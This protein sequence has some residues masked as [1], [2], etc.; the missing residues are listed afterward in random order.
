MM[1]EHELLKREIN[2][3]KLREQDAE[4]KILQLKADVSKKGKLLTNVETREFIL[5]QQLDTVQE[6]IEEEKTH[7]MNENEDLQVRIHEFENHVEELKSEIDSLKLN[8]RRRSTIEDHKDMTSLLTELQGF[9][10]DHEAEETGDISSRPRRK[11]GKGDMLDNLNKLMN[12]KNKP[13]K[14]KSLA[15]TVNKKELEE[16]N[17]KIGTYEKRIQSMTK[18]SGALQ[19]KIK[20]EIKKVELNKKHLA[21]KDQEIES[22]RQK[23]LET[24]M[25]YSEVINDINEQ[26]DSSYE[27]NRKLKRKLR[28]SKLGTRI[29][30]FKN[31]VL[32]L[33]D[34]K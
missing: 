16:M 4:K 8:R 22:L 15:S 14:K 7:M 11:T 25:G 3:Y 20:E 17:K 1:Q 34:Q 30:L 27:L 32:N 5:K 13:I 23:L 33:I 28:H 12:S 18:L 9:D 29:G 24:T 6:Q 31:S 26:L 10:E 19:K 2:D 21:R